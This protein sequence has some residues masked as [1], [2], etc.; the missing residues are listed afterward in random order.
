MNKE[1]KIH[2]NPYAND[3]PVDKR[4]PKTICGQK[5][6]GNETHIKNGVTCSVC[7]RMFKKVDTKMEE[8]RINS[9]TEEEFLNYEHISMGYHFDRIPL[10]KKQQKEAEMEFNEFLREVFGP[11]AG[12]NDDVYL[13]D[14]MYLTPDG[15]M[16]CDD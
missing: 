7:K 9:M 14:G 10:T 12:P 8:I 13:S 5:N 11:D 4:L 15:E 1:I 16:V 6:N 3:F 2:Y